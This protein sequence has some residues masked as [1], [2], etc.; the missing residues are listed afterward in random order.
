MYIAPL[1][2]IF[3]TEITQADGTTTQVISVQP[4]SN[5]SIRFNTKNNRLLLLTLMGLSYTG[6]DNPYL[7]LSVINELM[8]YRNKLVP[9]VWK[10]ILGF[11][12]GFT[13]DA[14]DYAFSIQRPSLFKNKKITANPFIIVDAAMRGQ[15]EMVLN[16]LNADPFVLLKKATV[17]NSVGV[18]HEVTPLQAAIM[19]TDVQM[20]EKM[21]EY[22]VRLT[23]DLNN[24]SIDGLAEMQSQIKTIYKKSLAHYG[25]IQKAALTNLKEKQDQLLQLP[26]L[27]TAQAKQADEISEK[28]KKITKRIIDYK[29]T[30]KKNDINE[31]IETHNQAQ[32][33]NAFDFQPYVDAICVMDEKNPIQKAELDVVMELIK[34]RTP[35]E[36]AAVIA[37]TGVASKESDAARAKLFPDLTLVEKLNRFREEFVNHMQQE[38]IF[39]PNHILTG[40][41]HNEKIWYEVDAGRIADPKHKKHSIIFFQLAGWAQRNAAE[42]VKQDIRQGTYYLIEKDEMRTR[43]SYFNKDNRTPQVCLNDDL[44][45][46]DGI[47]RNVLADVSLV[48]SWVVA[49]LG[50]KFAAMGRAQR[51]PRF[52]AP[53]PEVLQTYIE[54]KQKV[55]KTYIVNIC[56]PGCCCVIQ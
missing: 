20:V 32:E 11:L 14:G 13:A 12:P 34:A 55:W 40:L 3:T 4:L 28:I 37:H 43:Q 36:T 30:M 39:N 8:Y 41:R 51:W 44:N 45:N 54:Q 2:N 25:N 9:D 1:K 48:D 22:F 5:T 7:Y 42:P 53:K 49:G 35:E 15:E 31:I 50:Y 10:T 38:I 52:G 17:K 24:K 46:D 16:I 18:E 26:S 29:T 47:A 19:A 6:N 23:T 21:Q 56:R 27:T 33:H